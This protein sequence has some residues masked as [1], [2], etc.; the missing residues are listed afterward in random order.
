MNWTERHNI[1]FIATHLGLALASYNDVTTSEAI[2]ELMDA[3][4]IKAQELQF[5]DENFNEV[6]GKT[7]W[8]ADGLTKKGYQLLA[9][10]NPP[11]PLDIPSLLVRLDALEKAKR[12]RRIP[13]GI[14]D[15]M[16]KA[17]LFERKLGPELAPED[18]RQLLLI[19]R[20][21]NV[22][23]TVAALNLLHITDRNM[24]AAILGKDTTSA[25]LEREFLERLKVV[26][27][28][29]ISGL[30]WEGEMYGF[31]FY[32]EVEEFMKSLPELPDAATA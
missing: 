17:R 5:H 21:L 26:P 31:W 9:L 22:R 19:K 28:Y 20:A 12:V 30:L 1:V 10:H 6:P 23:H 32:E 15:L 3:G 29:E 18:V 16:Q 24:I 25:T 14:P 11:E 8:Q 2:K 27:V 13:A 7:F 4:L